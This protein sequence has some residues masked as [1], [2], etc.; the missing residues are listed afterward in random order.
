MR[1]LL[2]ALSMLYF[3]ATSAFAQV[4]VGINIS[5]FPDLVRVPGYPVYYAPRLG[6]NFFFYDGLYWVYE[7]DNWYASSWYNGPWRPVFPEY[8]PLFILRVPVRYYVSPPSYFRQ[9]R[10][11]GPPRWGQHWGRD[12]ERQR[13]GWDRW[14]RKAAPAPAPL[15][16][17]QRKYSG[18]RYPRS[19][20][21][22]RCKARIIVTGRVRPPF[23]NSCRSRQRN[24]PRHRFSGKGR[25]PPRSSVPCSRTSGV[26]GHR[27]S[28]APPSRRR[29]GRVLPP[30]G[31]SAGS[32]VM[33]TSSAPHQTSSSRGNVARQFRI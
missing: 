27:M 24:A 2:I 1:H 9:W 8:V 28:G 20:N 25:E 18:D 4:S 31:S 11:D 13:S 12:W 23:G 6:M 29:P 19:S 3:A 26:P 14:D 30:R 22:R 32:A 33:K 10:P 16:T 15:P 5:L 21:R 7:D 17:Y